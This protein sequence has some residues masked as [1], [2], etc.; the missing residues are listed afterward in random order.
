MVPGAVQIFLIPIFVVLARKATRGV[1]GVVACLIGVVG[2]IREWEPFLPHFVTLVDISVMF[3]V[4]QEAFGGRYVGYVLTLQYP[5]CIIFVITYITS[6]I[7]GT[8]KRFVFNIA[9]QAGFAV[10]NL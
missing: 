9:Y 5:I 3:V 1:A 4:P 2:A 10:G 7:S 6:G 8:T